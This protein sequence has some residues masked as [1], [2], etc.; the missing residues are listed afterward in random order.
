MGTHFV[1]KPETPV[2]DKNNRMNENIF[3]RMKENLSFFGWGNDVSEGRCFDIN[4]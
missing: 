2:N 3:Q 4:I 1:L